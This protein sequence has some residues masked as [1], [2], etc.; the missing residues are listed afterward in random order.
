MRQI[1]HWTIKVTW[2]DD[3]EEFLDHI[4]YCAVIENYLDELEKE[5][6]EETEEEEEDEDE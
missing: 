6:N 3:E 5:E 1:K 4:P 2:S